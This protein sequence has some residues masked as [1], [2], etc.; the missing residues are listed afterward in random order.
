MPGA[1]ERSLV[2]CIHDGDQN[3]F[4]IAAKKI[5]ASGYRPQRLIRSVG[6]QQDWR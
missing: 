3:K 6:A 4:V 1:H 5:E 2:R